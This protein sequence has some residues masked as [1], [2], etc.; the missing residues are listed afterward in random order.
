MQKCSN[1]KSFILFCLSKLS[2]Q[3]TKIFN[4]H[5]QWLKAYQGL[6]L[7]NMSCSPGQ[8]L[9]PTL[10]SSF[11]FFFY[12]QQQWRQNKSLLHV[13]PCITL[14]S[15]GTLHNRE[16][17]GYK[18]WITEKSTVDHELAVAEAAI[19]DCSEL[20]LSPFSSH[21]EGSWGPVSPW[22]TTDCWWL[23]EKHVFLSSV[24]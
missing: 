18:R 1:R 24:V 2:S 23:L 21:L 9:H 7:T 17:K 19:Q 5:L 15:Q 13:Q 3:K 8:M 11:F 12:S 10:T 6:F 16:W 20:D 22:Y 14:H 4:C